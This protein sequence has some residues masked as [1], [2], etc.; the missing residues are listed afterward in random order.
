MTGK[1]SRRRRIVNKINKGEVFKSLEEMKTL[2]YAGVD[3]TALK[4]LKNEG[5]IMF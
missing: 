2:K 5:E 4:F 3:G 1:E